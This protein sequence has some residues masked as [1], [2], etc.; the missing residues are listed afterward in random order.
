MLIRLDLTVDAGNQQTS[1][2][3]I[4]AY[5]NKQITLDLALKKKVYLC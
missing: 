3:I 1:S 5:K 2:Y 4:G